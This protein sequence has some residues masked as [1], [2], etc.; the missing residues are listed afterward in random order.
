M[1]LA[2][3]ILDGYQVEHKKINVERA[4][5]EQKGEYNPKLKPAKK[6]KKALEKLQKQQQK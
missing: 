6:K 4:K 5:F 1:D 3:Q 2:L